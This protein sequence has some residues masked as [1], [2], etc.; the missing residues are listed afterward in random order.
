VLVR[1]GYLSVVLFHGW[2]ELAALAA[3]RPTPPA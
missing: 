3:F 1:S 2:M